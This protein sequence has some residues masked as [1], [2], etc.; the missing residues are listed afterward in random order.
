MN[1]I[2]LNLPVKNVSKSVAFYTGLGFVENENFRSDNTACVVLGEITVMLLEHARFS[3]F[4]PLRIIDP[5]R[6]VQALF[7]FTVDSRVEVD[8]IT[9]KA[10]SLGAIEPSPKEDYPYMYGRSFI[11]PDGHLWGP[12]FY[13]E[14]ALT[15]E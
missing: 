2:Y 12:F 10:L 11:D 1:K 13:D 3:D 7:S 15:K 6:E 8:R 4:T 14:T 9:D 5:T